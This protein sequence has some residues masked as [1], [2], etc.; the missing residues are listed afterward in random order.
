M[1]T[2]QRVAVIGAGAFGTA[3]ADLFSGSGHEVTLWAF[4]ADLAA[5]MAERRENDL[6]LPGV[7][8]RESLRFTSDLAEAASAGQDILVSVMPSHAVREVWTRLAPALHE[9]TILAS[10]TKGVEAETL[11]LPAQVISERLEAAGGGRRALACL[12]GP[13][14]ARDLAERK[15]AAITAASDDPDAA[16]AIQRA[17]STPRFRIYA[18]GDPVGAQLG[19]ALKNVLAVAAGVADGLELGH[20]ARAALI[21]RGLAEIARLG[22]AMGARA[23]TFAGLSGMGDLILTC[24]G[25]LSRNRTVGLRLGRGEPLEAILE[26]MTAVAEGVS[27]APAAVGLAE[28]FGVEAPICRETRAVLFEGRDP[29]DALDALTSRPLGDE[30]P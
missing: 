11:L 1:M 2:P 10:A 17:L 4:E 18:S 3:L 21:T 29:R 30:W 23:E 7:S 25:D 22:A 14:F 5:R 16:R 12:S 6:Y 13:T 28:K 8:L 19:G 9:E 27:T 20:S 15:P 24:G 26:S